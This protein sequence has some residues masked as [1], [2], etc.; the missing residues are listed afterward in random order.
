MQHRMIASMEKSGQRMAQ[1]VEDL[2]DLALT[3]FGSSIP[4][5]RTS[6]DLNTLLREVIA[7]VGASSPDA[8]IEFATE[9]T[10][11]GEWD[12]TRLAQ[13]F[14]NLLSNAIQHGGAGM[15]IKV[16]ATPAGENSVEVAF[17]NEGPAI[18]GDQVK[19]L[20]SPMK[21]SPGKRDRRHLGL[22]LYIVDKIV[23]AHGGKVGVESS[24]G[25]GT[26]FHVTLPQRGGQDAKT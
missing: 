14:A 2:L 9:G 3:R 4:L 24:D 21:S 7:E 1:L 18:P 20:F 25:A 13:A 23:E 16:T 19:G 8:Q 5:R 26:T 15:P 11:I 17:R 6:V 12:R 22:G 10:L